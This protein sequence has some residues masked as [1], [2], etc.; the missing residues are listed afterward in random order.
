MSYGMTV[1]TGYTF[2]DMVVSSEDASAM[3][4]GFAMED[5]N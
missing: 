2:T 3:S 1:D 4:F 5:K